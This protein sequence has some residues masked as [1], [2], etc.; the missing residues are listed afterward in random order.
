MGARRFHKEKPQDPPVPV[1]GS[2]EFPLTD[3][4]RFLQEKNWRPFKFDNQIRWIDPQNEHDRSY[5]E[6]E[7]LR[8]EGI[9]SLGGK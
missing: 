6:S 5:T 7:A 2:G 8:I 1:P 3:T 4:V 9:R